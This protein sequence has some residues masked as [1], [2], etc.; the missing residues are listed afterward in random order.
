M[1]NLSKGIALF[2]QFDPARHRYLNNS[3]IELILTL[4]LLLLKQPVFSSV[5]Y[6]KD[7]LECGTGYLECQLE[8]RL[9]VQ[10]GGS[11]RLGAGSRLAT[12]D[13]LT[14]LVLLLR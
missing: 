4:N 14:A 9:R 3:V 8:T 11:C 5:Y 7:H 13:L 2:F 10:K 6:N 1:T 12:T